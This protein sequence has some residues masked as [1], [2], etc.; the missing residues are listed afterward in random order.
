MVAT[1]KSISETKCRTII[2]L[3]ANG[4]NVQAWEGAYH[5]FLQME[6]QA[7]FMLRAFS[8]PV[9]AQRTLA[10]SV[11]VQVER[12]IKAGRT[13]ALAQKTLDDAL[14][15]EE[16]S[17]AAPDVALEDG[18]KA[19]K[20]KSGTQ[21]TRSQSEGSKSAKKPKEEAAK[22]EV[23]AELKEVS[24]EG[25]VPTGEARARVERERKMRVRA[26]RMSERLAE[27]QDAVTER[28]GG[29]T[30]VSFLNPLSALD[31]DDEAD[32]EL[33]CHVHTF[34][35]ETL[36]YAVEDAEHKKVRMHID[37]M[38]TRSLADIPTHVTTGV[39]P[40]NVYE[41]YRRV[42]VYFDDVSRQV[43]MEKIDDELNV[44]SM[45][46]RESFASFTSRFRDI[47][48]RMTE[49]S[50]WQDPDLMLSKL[51]RALNASSKVGGVIAV[52]QQVKMV[53]G[54]TIANTTD[55]LSAMADPMRVFEKN[56]KVA[57]DKVKVAQEKVNALHASDRSKSGRGQGAKGKGRGGKGGKGS[58]DSKDS[59]NSKGAVVKNP[60]L[61]FAEGS[62]THP[63]CF[64]NHVALGAEAIKELKAK[65]AKSQATK[66]ARWGKAPQKSGGV[67][68]TTE[69]ANAFKAGATTE[70]SL[71][72]KIK[73]L[74]AEGLTEE[75][76]LKVA[77]VLLGKK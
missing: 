63:N 15:K 72:D 36:R 2:A 25:T 26:L 29:Q 4:A 76:I 12:A 21:T 58:K 67:Y 8:M 30:M 38:L 50:M 37:G 43:L 22:V 61:R 45:R 47:E 10:L 7:H 48:H 60:C 49:V 1:I 24:G 66:Q 33:V 28:R 32:R 55:L 20:P 52:L 62:C 56:K 65:V 53:V 59:K 75:H 35:G 3:A 34:D 23:S 14:R 44:M 77:D 9:T 73:G 5:A 51:E 68:T 18:A 42:V 46:D 71:I 74:S 69:V 39:E 41:R 16:N 19:E 17:S 57:Q 40:G 27:A 54:L 70:A 13:K 6:N 11:D 31:L 64:Y